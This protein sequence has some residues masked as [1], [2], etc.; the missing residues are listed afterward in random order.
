[1]VRDA[2]A[3]VW[4]WRPAFQAGFQARMEWCV[5]PA[6]AANHAPQA[7]FRGEVSR[8]IV[9]LKARPGEEIRLDA[10]GSKDP[11]GDRRS[12]RWDAYP[13]AGTYPGKVVVPMG[14]A[15]EIRLRIP[16]DAAGKSIHVILEVSDDGTP[17]LTS[18]RRIVLLA[19]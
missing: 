18:Y 14:S 12:Y 8:A 4:R 7:G 2:R 1:G 19:E 3:S 13:E 17:A 5:K 6:R 10:A 11:D 9:Q 16:A 15:S